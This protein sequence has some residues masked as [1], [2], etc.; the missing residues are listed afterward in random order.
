MW[1]HSST[2]GLQGSR[3]SSDPVKLGGCGRVCEGGSWVPIFDTDRAWRPGSIAVCNNA[4]LC[5]HCGPRR[6][7]E[8]AVR[9]SWHFNDW[10]ASG[11]QLIHIRLS[12]P[13]TRADDAAALLDRLKAAERDLRRSPAWRRVGICDWVRV[14]HVRWSPDAGYNVHYHVT[15]FVPAARPVDEARVVAELQGA[16]RDRLV[17]AGFTRVSKRNGLFARVITSGLRALYAW[18]WADTDDDTDDD[19]RYH[20]MGP[21]DDDGYHPMGERDG[22]GSL[23]LYE[24]AE[25]ALAGDRVAWRV[26]EEL[27]RALKGVPVVRASRMLD[28]IWAAEQASLDDTEAPVELGEPVVLV[29]ARL[30][31]R[32]RRDG[33]TQMGLAVGRELGLDAMA[34]W[35][36]THLHVSVHLVDHVTPRLVLATGPPA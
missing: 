17:R 5:D 8:S 15:A 34:Q 33:C 7:A 23:A 21:A 29:D 16:W 28:R 24:V 19:D 11:G 14:L 10:L 18:S 27:C 20:P 26:W 4:L 30:W 3:A 35:W 25:R 1:G 9:F 32:A 2:D 12:V 22:R 31:E 36:A 6:Q 13:H